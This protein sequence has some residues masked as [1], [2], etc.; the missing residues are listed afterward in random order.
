VGGQPWAIDFGD[1]KRAFAF[2]NS[3]VDFL[4]CNGS[5]TPGVCNPNHLNTGLYH[6]RVPNWNIKNSGIG[7]KWDFQ[8]PHPSIRFALTD[9]WGIAQGPTFVNGTI[10][11]AAD[12]NHPGQLTQ[13][14]VIPGPFAGPRAISSGVNCSKLATLSGGFAGNFGPGLASLPFITTNAKSIHLAKGVNPHTFLNNC[15]FF[16]G[17]EIRYHKVNTLGLSADYFEPFTGVVIRVESSWT[18]NALVNDTDSLDFTSNN[19]IMQYVVGFDRP[20]FI[21]FL[22]PDRTFF[23]SF[24]VFETYYPGAHSSNGGKDGIVTGVNDFTFTAFT[25]THY[26]RDQIIPLIFAA[27]GSEGTDATV[28]GNT[29]WLINDHWSAVLGFDAFLGKSH[30]HN[31]GAIAWLNTRSAPQDQAYSESVFGQAHM[32]A[33]GAQRNTDD[34][35]WTRIRYRF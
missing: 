16:Q 17:D 14:N 15:G 8:L 4:A 12:P 11:L 18:H 35:F 20:H 30:Q 1:S 28:G 24:Q 22:N 29:E 6:E 25:Q 21:K 3:S 19:D 32:G 5:K 33:G 26:Y 10:T 23:S 13:G 27:F 34:E 7:M 2:D 31:V 9:W